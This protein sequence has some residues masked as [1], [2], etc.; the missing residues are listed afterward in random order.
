MNRR[1]LRQLEIVFIAMVV[2]WGGWN[3]RLLGDISLP[4]I[5]SDHMV[6]QQTANVKVWGT[7][8]AGQKLIVKF[9]GNQT[10][11]TADAQGNWQCR[12]KTGR[13]SGPYELEVMAEEGLPKVKFS[14][15]WIGEVW[16]C[17][18]QAAMKVSQ[19]L[20]A[21]TEIELSKNYQNLRLFTVGQ[22]ASAEPLNDFTKVTPWSVCSPET[23]KDFSATAYFFGREVSK[24]VKDVKIGLID[25]S[26]SGTV[27]EAWASRGAMEKVPELLPLLKHSDEN[28]EPTSPNRTGNLFNGMIAPMTDFPVRGVIWYQGEANNGRGAQYATLFPTLI[29]G[30]RQQFG[31]G[32]FPFYFVQLAPYRYK[33]ESPESLAELREAQLKTL[34]TV[35]RT[36]MVVTTDIGDIEEIDPKNKQ[37]VG[38]RLALIALADVYQECLPED[39]RKFAFS[40]PIFESAEKGENCIWIKFA[41]AEGGLRI[42]NNEKTLTGFT[43]SGKDGKFVPAVARIVG[44]KVQVSSPEIENPTEV[45]FAWY[46][47][48]Q[49]NLVNQELLPAS[50][51]RTDD[52]PLQSE[53]RD[54]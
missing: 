52:F 54:F 24:Q 11:T 41:H 49:P 30:W 17:S 39:Q 36:G 9:A 28:D 32:D 3:S 14:N 26:W 18:G 15:V 8:E 43:I 5:F 4:K 31:M 33:N 42:R 47:T 51:F 6:L 22:F 50:P 40:G 20:N 45:R 46:D 23:V 44:E 7:A 38:R 29:K 34:K 35:P 2:L 25:A 53:G 19:A 10:K 37:S 12:I 21:K 16:I 48:A 27:C 1:T 13:A